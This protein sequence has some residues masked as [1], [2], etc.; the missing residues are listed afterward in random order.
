M[1]ILSLVFT[2][3]PILREI[4]KPIDHID[5]QLRKLATDM[6]ET[7]YAS[8][9]VGMAAVQI[10]VA[11]RLVVIDVAKPDE[12]PAPLILVNPEIV[13]VSKERS[14]F[15][16]GCLSIPG[17]MAE[18]DRPSKIAIR[19]ID[20]ENADRVLQAH[21]ILATCIQHEIDHLNGIL[22]TDYLEN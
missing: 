5:R 12:E 6:L 17:V 11:R 4:S 15:R 21:G 2:P 7:M 9:G 22:F 16:E 10:G 8:R 1:T 19:Y 20:L 18:L 14:F 13:S 3:Q